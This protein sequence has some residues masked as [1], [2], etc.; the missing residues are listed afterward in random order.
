[1]FL[2]AGRALTL[3]KLGKDFTRAVGIN[4]A[5]KLWCTLEWLKLSSLGTI[6]TIKTRLTRSNFY[7][8]R[9]SANIKN[10]LLDPTWMIIPLVKQKMKTKKTF[11]PLC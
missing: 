2:S 9:N 10:I 11:Y 1:M 5:R 3:G 4:Q 6:E 7:T 8:F